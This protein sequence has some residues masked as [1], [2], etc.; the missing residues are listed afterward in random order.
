[1][2]RMIIPI[3]PATNVDAWDEEEAFFVSF[4]ADST[5]LTLEFELLEDEFT[6]SDWIS[7]QGETT[8]TKIREA[9][10]ELHAALVALKEGEE[11]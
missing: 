1:M 5:E 6:V 9:F 8:V 11:E 2:N 3:T 10:A 4:V 7:D